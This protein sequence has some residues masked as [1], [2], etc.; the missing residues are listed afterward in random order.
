ML[1]SV[2]VTSAQGVVAIGDSDNIYHAIHLDANLGSCAPIMRKRRMAVNLVMSLDPG[3]DLAMCLLL[4]V[5][6]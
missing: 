4:R 3:I 1:E 5:K 2:T 6:M